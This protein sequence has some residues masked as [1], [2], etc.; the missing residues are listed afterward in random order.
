MTKT[1]VREPEER[2]RRSRIKKDERR[3]NPQLHRH[4]AAINQMTSFLQFVRASDPSLLTRA[5]PGDR[6][7][8][9]ATQRFPGLERDSLDSGLVL[10]IK[11]ESCS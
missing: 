4:L 5:F 3:I 11:L 10:R 6:R 1:P 2:K 9:G 7:G 8:W